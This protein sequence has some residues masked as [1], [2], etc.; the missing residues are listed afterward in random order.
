MD[1]TRAPKICSK[2]RRRA[3]SGR[4]GAVT[5]SSRGRASGRTSSRLLLAMLSAPQPAQTRRLSDSAAAAASR[6][7]RSP[8]CTHC[9]SV[10]WK[11]WRHRGQVKVA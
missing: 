1:L 7:G 4:P 3:G 10:A 5:N 6:S 9:Q 2:S 8:A 11:G